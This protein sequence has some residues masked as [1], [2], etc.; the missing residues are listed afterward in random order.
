MSHQ[1][2][3]RGILKHNSGTDLTSGCSHSLERKKSQT[4]DEMNIIATYHPE[5]KDYGFQ[6]VDEPNTPYY[7][8]LADEF[9]NEA[10]GSSSQ[11]GV[12]AEKLALRLTA[13]D[14]MFPKVV[15]PKDSDSSDEEDQTNLSPEQKAVEKQFKK[16]RKT[17]YDE[18]MHLRLAR[19]LLQQETEDDEEPEEKPRPSSKQETRRRK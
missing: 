18:G 13:V 17:H 15:M 11:W 8:M 9:E 14:K 5:N 10:S 6:K 12:S 3:P 19:K 2:P 1:S 16:K 4:W 7:S